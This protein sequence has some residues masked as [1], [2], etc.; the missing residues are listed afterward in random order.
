M[1]AA[2]LATA[3]AAMV[4]G[5]FVGRRSAASAGVSVLAA[6]TIAQGGMV[7]TLGAVRPGPGLSLGVL[8]VMAFVNGWRS[9]LASGL[10]MDS[11][12]DDKL[13]VMSMRAAANQF[14]YLLGAALGGLALAAAGFAAL[15]TTYSA[16][17]VLGAV[18]HLAPRIAPDPGAAE[19]AA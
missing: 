19:A 3:A 1:V 18:L 7:L 16:L 2:G 8:T 11:A 6:L 12:P 10:G 13:T 4:P 9:V 17:F 14:G 5:T 15:G